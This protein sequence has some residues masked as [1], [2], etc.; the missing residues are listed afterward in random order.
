MNEVT[1]GDKIYIS[2]KRA[3]EITGYAK[4]YVGQ[5]CRE[6][7]VDAKMIGRGWYVYEPSIRAHRFGPEAVAETTPE[8]VSEA[9]VP[10]A[11]TVPEE[12]IWP[13]QSWDKPLYTAEQPQE[14]PQIPVRAYEAVVPPAEDTLTDMQIAW[15]EWFDQKQHELQTPEIES[16]EVIDARSDVF[17]ADDEDFEDEIEHEQHSEVAEDTDDEVDI[18]FHRIAREEDVEEVEHPSPEELYEAEGVTEKVEEQA[19]EPIKIRPIAYPMPVYTPAPAPTYP[20]RTEAYATPQS[21][22]PQEARIISERVIPKREA[23]R[24]AKKGSRRAARTDGSNAPMIA[25]LVGISLITIA[26]AFIGSGLAD[27][28]VQTFSS[29]NVVIDFLTGTRELK[30]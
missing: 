28:Y 4:D 12:P 6:G 5:L 20:T 9:E 18:P 26:I 17:V 3:A 11:E 23:S 19:P 22:Q 8:S 16:P 14:L 15:K 29:H 27:K 30:R 10:E 25:L 7:H 21:Q 13:V 2:S 1:L 24:A